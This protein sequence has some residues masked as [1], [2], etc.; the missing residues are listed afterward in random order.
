[1]NLILTVIGLAIGIT[2]VLGA[3]ILIEQIVWRIQGRPSGP[4]WKAP[5]MP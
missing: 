3:T 5:W 2:L 4:R 1:M